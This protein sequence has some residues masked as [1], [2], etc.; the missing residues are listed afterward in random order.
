MI[1]TA[2]FFDAWQAL[3]QL[4]PGLG[5]IFA[6]LVAM[7]AF[8]TFWFWFRLHGIKF[9]TAKRSAIMG[10]GFFIELIPILNILPAWTLAVTLVITDLRIKKSKGES[11]QPV[12]KDTAV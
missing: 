11:T 12:E 5:Q 2:L 3:I 7:F 1:S 9:S 6:S 10:G 8:M 4:I